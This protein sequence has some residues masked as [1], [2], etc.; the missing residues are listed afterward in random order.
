[1]TLIVPLNAQGINNQLIPSGG[2][3]AV[4][5][6]VSFATQADRLIDFREVTMRRQI[7]AVQTVMWRN[8]LDEQI[9]LNP[10]SLGTNIVIPPRSCG[11]VPIVLPAPE[12]LSVSVATAG[13]GK[14][15]EL[16]FLNVPMPAAVWGIDPIAPPAPTPLPER[17]NVATYI[18]DTATSGDVLMSYVVTESGSLLQT[19]PGAGPSRV[20]VGSLATGTDETI[21]VYVNGTLSG[22]I[23]ITTTG[24]E[25]S[26]PSDAAIEEDDVIWLQAVTDLTAFGIAVT[27]VTE[28]D[29]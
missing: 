2:P 19:V 3:K 17:S 16:T 25:I 4:A 12:Q 23:T 13:A 14:G 6:V 8:T 18:P 24:A 20:R 11:I 29:A 1:M 9:S 21:G 10:A 7:E 15:V 26:I 28:G 22:T 27:L 5:L